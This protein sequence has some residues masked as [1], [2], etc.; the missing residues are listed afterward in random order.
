MPTIGWMDPAVALRQRTLPE[1]WPLRHSD[2]EVAEFDTEFVVFDPRSRMA[3]HLVREHALVFE[4]CDGR[5][6]AEL[7]IRGLV[8]AGH[9]SA[10][11]VAAVLADALSDLSALGLLEGTEPP[12]PP[13][14]VGCGASKPAQRRRRGFR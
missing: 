9:G 10:E 7:L 3:H 11:E 1:R 13:P 14:C 8:E 2:V 6:S 4:S 12:A 5:S